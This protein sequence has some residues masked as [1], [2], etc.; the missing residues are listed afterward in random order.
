MARQRWNP[1]FCALLWLTTVAW[2]EP[3]YSSDG[4]FSAELSA[5]TTRTTAYSESPIG[6]I[7]TI[8]YLDRQPGR[9]LTVSYTDLPKLALLA[10]RERIFSDARDEML[11]QCG[12]TQHDWQRIDT[13]SRRL[14]YQLPGQRGMTLF[15]MEKFR[16]Y[17]VD[18][19]SDLSVLAQKDNQFLQ[20]F[21]ILS[22]AAASAVI[23]SDL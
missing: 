19:R 4:R 20:S 8:V 14:N 18:V 2:A 1:G 13:L 17:V 15:Y 5:A 16:L 9:C 7:T 21:K 22:P 10:G 3:Y 12:A 23:P 6:T 11:Q